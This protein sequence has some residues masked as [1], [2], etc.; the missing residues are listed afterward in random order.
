MSKGEEGSFPDTFAERRVDMNRRRDV[1]E[2][3]A[4]LQRQREPRRKLGY[5]LADGLQAEHEMIVRPRDDAHEAILCL[6]RHGA[7]IGGEGEAGG[8]D[9]VA[10]GARC[11][12]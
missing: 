6:E 9:R 11:V 4:H 12:R 7:A 5:A 8:L 2:P 1:L 3:R 10:G